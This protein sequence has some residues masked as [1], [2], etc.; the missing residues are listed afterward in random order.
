MTPYFEKP[1]RMKNILGSW[2]STNGLTQFRC[3][4]TAKYAHV[5][6]FFNDYREAPF[7]GEHRELPHPPRV[8]TSDEDSEVAAC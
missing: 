3:A 7:E 8:P 2:L 1:P 4:A 5:T 6:C